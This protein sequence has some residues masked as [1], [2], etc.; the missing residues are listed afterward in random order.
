MCVHFMYRNRLRY[1][2]NVI[3][4]FFCSSF[5]YMKKKVTTAAMAA[6][7]TVKDEPAEQSNLEEPRSAASHLPSPPLILDS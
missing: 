4:I 6:A 3:H 7:E 5:V 1:N 2:C